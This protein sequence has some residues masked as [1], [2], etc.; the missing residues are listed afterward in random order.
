[1]P[2]I[3]RRTAGKLLLTAPALPAA[4][5]AAAQV[6]DAPKPSTFAACV[7]ASDPSLGADERA[8]VEKG[9]GSLESSLAAIRD[10]KLPADADPALRFSALKSR[11][12]R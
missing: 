5:F 8:R 10:F 3:S 11:G 12:S 1:M 9:I 6:A 4:A 7:A 2:R